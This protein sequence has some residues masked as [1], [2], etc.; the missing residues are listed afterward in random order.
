MDRFDDFFGG[1]TQND[2]GGY[3]PVYHTP[4][5]APAPER[6]IKR[7]VVVLMVVISVIMCLALIVNIVVLTS[8]KSEIASEYAATIKQAVY[9]E[10]YQAIKDVVDD[11]GMV[12]DDL[13]DAVVGAV[14][15]S[16]AKVAGEQ[17]TKSVVN[18]IAKNS[19][20]STYSSSS[21]FLITAEDSSGGRKQ[22]VVTNAHCVLYAKQSSTGFFPGGMGTSATF[23]EYETI[24]CYFG[25]DDS[26]SYTL[27]VVGCGSYYDEEVNSTDY[28]REP[29]LAVLEFT[30]AQP[31][32]S[33]H[34]SLAVAKSDT[35]TYGDDIAI[36]GYPVYE[37]ISVSD[38]VICSPAHSM[39]EQGWG[40]GQF[41][42]I[43]AAVNSGNSGGPLVNNRNEVLGVVEASMNVEVAE[44][45]GY[46]VAASTL[47]TFL[48]EY[49]LTV[50]DPV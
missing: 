43:S 10:Y 31:D 22:Y 42:T 46:A 45:I 6:G 24:T 17:T 34:P 21:G 19:G 40:Y 41:Y 12:S 44:N 13:I 49:G 39:L 9:D 26:D 18:I 1:D 7:W 32:S 33:E 16:A 3:T 4:D 23:A 50:V 36:V 37:G 15:T 48:D 2:G 5:P 14:N 8:L 35:A 20:A 38:G 29:D 11:T 25:N 27:S 47:I 28:Q 30:S